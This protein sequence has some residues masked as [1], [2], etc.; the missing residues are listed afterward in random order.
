MSDE[1]QEVTPAKKRKPKNQPLPSLEGARY[2]DLES[3]AEGIGD[4]RMKQNKL[5][6][7]EAEHVEAAQES[8]RKYKLTIFKFGG[9]ELVRVPGGEKMR[10]RLVKDTPKKGKARE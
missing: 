9:V 5:A 10:V 7:A 4:I 1:T 2:D 6:A 8:M 3:L